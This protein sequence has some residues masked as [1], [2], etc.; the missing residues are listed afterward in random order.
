MLIQVINDTLQLVVSEVVNTAVAVHEATGGSQI[1]NGV[2]NG[3]IGSV[4]SLII[5][6]AIRHF[7]KKKIKKRYNKQ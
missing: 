4:I 2:D 7:E 1:I 5:A 3:I 6:A